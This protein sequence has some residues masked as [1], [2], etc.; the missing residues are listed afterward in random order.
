MLPTEVRKQLDELLADYP[1]PQSAV[2]P[3]LHL[4]QEDRGY[5]SP[6]TVAEIAEYFNLTPA[7]IESVASFYTMLKKRPTGKHLLQVC[8]NIS[9]SLMGARHI[10]EHISQ[11]LEVS[12]GETTA[13]GKFTLMTVECLGTC[14]TAPVMQVN[15]TF[16][17]NL[18]PEKVDEL[19]A[20]LE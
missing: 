17:E 6:E 5:L 15:N 10:V 13:D 7:D 1:N 20:S 18:T 9:C 11:R 3:A 8:T 19:L 4:A 16:Y 12:E 2:V 14:G